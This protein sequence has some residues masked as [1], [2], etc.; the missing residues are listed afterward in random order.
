MCSRYADWIPSQSYYAFA[1]HSGCFGGT[2]YGYETKSKTIFDCLI[3]KDTHTLQ[4]ASFYTSASANYG[5]SPS[6]E[7][8]AIWNVRHLLTVDLLRCRNMGFLTRD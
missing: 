4:N 8:L 2:A 5:A 1:A 6:A 3:S 7:A